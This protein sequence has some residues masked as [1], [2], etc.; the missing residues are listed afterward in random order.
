M[1]SQKICI[2]TDTIKMYL[3]LKKSSSRSEQ[4][5]FFHNLTSQNT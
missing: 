4:D 1:N 3:N 2:K 5:N